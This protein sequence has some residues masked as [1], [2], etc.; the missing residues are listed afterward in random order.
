MNAIKTLE[1]A[2]DIIGGDRQRTHGPDRED[3]R[4][5]AALWETYLSVRRNPGGALVAEDAA[6]MMELLKLARSQCGEHNSDDYVDRCGY[7]AIAGELA[8]KG[9]RNE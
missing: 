6:N 3:F 5:I 9:G 8:G 1:T 2:L 4:K 7:A